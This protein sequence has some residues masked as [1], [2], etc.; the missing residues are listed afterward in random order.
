MQPSRPCKGVVSVP[1]APVRHLL[2]RLHRDKALAL[3]FYAAWGVVS[4]SA[5]VLLSRVLGSFV[6][7]VFSVD[8]PDA[9]AGLIVLLSA[10]AGL[11]APATLSSIRTH[12]DSSAGGRE[13]GLPHTSEG[14]SRRIRSS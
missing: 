12:T 7:S 4:A 5:I 3:G 1:L 11:S 8:S 13:S 10:V 2:S 14:T 6:S 9:T